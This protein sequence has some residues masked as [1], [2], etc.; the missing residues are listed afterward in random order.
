MKIE[1]INDLVFIVTEKSDKDEKMAGGLLFRPETSSKDYSKGVVFAVGPGL[2]TDQGVL[3]A[4]PVSKGDTVLF[5]PQSGFS[6]K[7]DSEEFIVMHARELLA[8]VS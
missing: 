7:V 2:Y 4:P 8:R 5:P 3:L 1:P 6:M